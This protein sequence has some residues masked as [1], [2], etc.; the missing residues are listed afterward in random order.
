M[1]LGT[2][3]GMRYYVQNSV[4]SVSLMD[5]FKTEGMKHLGHTD[6]AIIKHRS[7][8]DQSDEIGPSEGG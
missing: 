4:G 1:R 2:G 3:L 7:K 8:I 6:K 5:R